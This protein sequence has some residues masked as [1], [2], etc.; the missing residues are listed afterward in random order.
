MLAMYNCIRE[1]SRVLVL[2]DECCFGYTCIK[3]KEK[4]NIQAEMIE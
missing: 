2:R 1:F 3:M 4:N